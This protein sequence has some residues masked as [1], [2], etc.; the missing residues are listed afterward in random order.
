MLIVILYE[1]DNKCKILF[2]K[3]L[4]D[5]IALSWMTYWARIQV[6]CNVWSNIFNATG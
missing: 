6:C 1:I 2:I 3:G 4:N 5:N